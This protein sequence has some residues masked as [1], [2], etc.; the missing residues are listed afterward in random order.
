MQADSEVGTVF[1]QAAVGDRAKCHNTRCNN[2]TYPGNE[3]YAGKLSFILIFGDAA[4]G[5]YRST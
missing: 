3:Q 5:T 2:I 4:T 1:G